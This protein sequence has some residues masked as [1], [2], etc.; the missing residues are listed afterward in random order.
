MLISL[1]LAGQM[2]AAI[3]FDHYGSVGFPQHSIN[4]GRIVGALMVISGVIFI[5][6]F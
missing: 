3:L 2:I 5:Q 6:R 1:A 4:L